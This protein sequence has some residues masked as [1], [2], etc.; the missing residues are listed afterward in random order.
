MY[1]IQADLSLSHLKQIAS[2]RE[3][4]Y[5]TRELTRQGQCGGG[6]GGRHGTTVGSPLTPIQWPQQGDPRAPR[7]VEAS[8]FQF[9]EAEL[10]PSHPSLIPGLP[11]PTHRCVSW[12]AEPHMHSISELL[13]FFF[14]CN[15][16]CSP[17]SEGKFFWSN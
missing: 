16:R 1:V 7:P 2:P 17:H 12:W 8:P 10:S 6:R 14:S 5:C 9:R 15:D 3:V 13:S 11:G 4:D